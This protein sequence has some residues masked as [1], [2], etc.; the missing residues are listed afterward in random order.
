[1]KG[2][3]RDSMERGKTDFHQYNSELSWSTLKYSI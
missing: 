2:L 1:M 3:T